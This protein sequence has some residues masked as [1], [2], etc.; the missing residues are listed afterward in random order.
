ML[1]TS[2]QGHE[3]MCKNVKRILAANHRKELF[4]LVSREKWK[5]TIGRAGRCDFEMFSAGTPAGDHGNW[6]NG[7]PAEEHRVRNRQHAAR[8]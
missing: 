4:R 2:V 5:N 3:K 7:E 6:K 1:L 8:V